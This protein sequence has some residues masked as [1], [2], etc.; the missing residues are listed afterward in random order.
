MNLDG[1]RRAADPA[2]GAGDWRTSGS[3]SRFNTLARDVT[4]NLEKFELGVAV[5]KLY[6][7]IWD[8]FCDWYIELCKARLQ[9]GETPWAPGGCCCMS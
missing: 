1:T 4:E 6:D 2:G 8:D 5:Q 7:F 3:S 9:G